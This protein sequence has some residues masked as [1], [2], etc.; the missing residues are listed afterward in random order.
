MNETKETVMSFI[1]TMLFVALMMA[2]IVLS[3]W[4]RTD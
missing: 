2:A 1:V 3:E 4:I